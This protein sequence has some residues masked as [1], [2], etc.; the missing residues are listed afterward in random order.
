MKKNVTSFKPV[1]LLNI[2]SL[3]AEPLEVAIQT[4]RAPALKFLMENGSYIPNM[5]TSFPTM[6]VTIDS[7][8]LTGTYADKHHIPGLNWFDDSR[9]EIINYGTGFRE[10]FRLGMR[11]SVHNMLYRLNNEHM[12]SEV[13]TIYEELADRGIPSASINSFV[14]RGNTPQRLRVPRLFS[15]LTRFKDGKWTTDATTIFSLGTFSKLR[16]WGVATQI[17]AGNYKYTARELRY[18]IRKRKLPGFTFCIFQDMDARIHFKGPMDIKG[19]AKIDR[20]IQKTLNLYPSWEE[21]LNRNIWLVMGDNGQSPTGSRYRDFIID[22]RK[23]L[24]KYRI[25]R[26]ERPVSVKDQL[27]LCVNQRM[28]YIY[29]LDQQLPLSTIAEVLKNDQ[30]I[31]IIAWKDEDSIHVESGMREGSL[32]FHPGGEY[33][34]VYHQTWSMEGDYQLLDLNLTKEK[35]LSYGDYPDAFVRLHSVLHSHSGRYIVVNAK[36][37][38]EFKAQ[39]TPFHLAGAAHGSLHKQESLV[40]LIISGTTEKPI[41][42][43]VVDLKAYILK[44]IP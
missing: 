34:D 12:S 18:L 9:K 11:R 38:C 6:S 43:R 1:I 25:S 5:V 32:Q 27:V 14:Y 13:T 16:S 44:L 36:P 3:M 42:R 24:K 23:Q 28:A 4:G 15:T 20:E 19:I 17:A 2:D 29:V 8:L 7:S 33:T 21:A 26:I 35:E 31:D 40:P 30:R 39:S 10:T 41:F 22:L 37:G